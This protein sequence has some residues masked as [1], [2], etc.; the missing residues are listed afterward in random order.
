MPWQGVYNYK[1]IHALYLKTPDILYFTRAFYNK[2]PAFH[3]LPVTYIYMQ[4]NTREINYRYSSM[5]FAHMHINVS[6][7]DF[8]F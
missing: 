8:F 2:M 4:V 3:T 1:V 6:E 5:E 7:I